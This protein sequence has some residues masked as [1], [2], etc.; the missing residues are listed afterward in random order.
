MKTPFF[1]TLRLLNNNLD[2][3][4][5]STILCLFSCFRQYCMLLLVDNMNNVNSV[6]KFIINYFVH[7]V[8]DLIDVTDHVTAGDIAGEQILYICLE[9]S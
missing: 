9:V 7:C 8:V 6:D 1:L 3:I 5:L 4:S 2:P